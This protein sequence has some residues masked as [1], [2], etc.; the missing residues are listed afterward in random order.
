MVV[1]FSFKMDLDVDCKVLVWSKESI[2]LL[3][4]K[5]Y[6]KGRILYINVLFFVDKIIRGLMN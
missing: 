4:E 1:Y 6:G 5:K 3:W 2:L